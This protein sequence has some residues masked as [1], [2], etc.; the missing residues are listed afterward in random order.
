M[1]EPYQSSFHSKSLFLHVVVEDFPS[2]R[3]SAVV[4]QP[5]TSGYGYQASIVA[6]GCITNGPVFGEI[7]EGYLL[8]FHIAEA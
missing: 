5:P 8:K 4:D 2:A 6:D 7:I 3:S 1:M